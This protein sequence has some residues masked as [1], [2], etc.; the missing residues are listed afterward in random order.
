MRIA[1]TGAALML[2]G[3]LALAACSTADDAAAPS[4]PRATSASEDPTGPA[5]PLTPL[6]DAPAGWS[7]I[8]LGAVTLDVPDGFAVVQEPAATD[9]PD[10]SWIVRYGD[11]DGERAAITVVRDP[12]PTRAPADTAAAALSAA[13]AQHSVQDDASAGLAWPGAEA[14]TYLTYLQGVRVGGTAVEHRAEWVYADLADGSQVVVGVFAP[15]DLFDEL[16]MHDVL[17]TWRPA[18]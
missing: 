11:Q 3:V 5:A 8:E 12:A 6:A 4:T 13:R 14:A 17:A 16:Q 18:G 2:V 10:G 7:R 9:A 15:L 1:R